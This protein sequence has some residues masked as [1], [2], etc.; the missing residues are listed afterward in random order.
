[1][2]TTRVKAPDKNDYKKLTRLVKY[3]RGTPKPY[4]TL[5]ADDTHIV[6]WWIDTS[7]AVRKDMIAI[8]WNDVARQVIG[9]LSIKWTESEHEKSSAEAELVGCAF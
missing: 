5:E 4:L 1:V 2:L 7:F 6:K 3:L 9:L 8:R